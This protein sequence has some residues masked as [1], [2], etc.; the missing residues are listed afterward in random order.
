MAA[1]PSTGWISATAIVAAGAVG[2][3]WLALR[4]PAGHPPAPATTAAPEAAPPG[5]GAPA[6][7][8]D[9]VDADPTPAPPTFDVV[10]VEP[11]GQAVVAGTA[12]P[13]AAVTIYAD[14]TPLAETT[15]DSGGNFVAIFRAEPTAGPRALTLGAA[16]PDG[17]TA[18]STDV[19]MMLPAAPSSDV[20]ATETAAVPAPTPSASPAT[21]ATGQQ[22]EPPGTAAETPAPTV[23]ATAILR[24]GGV[25]VTPTAA[26]ANPGAPPGR[27]RQVS[28][29][30]ISYATTGDVTLAGLGT[31]GATLRAYVD[32]RLVQEAQVAP[33]GRWSL[34]LD[35]VAAGLYRL[36][37]DQLGSGGR[38]A[39]RVET[40]L[41]RDFPKAP[42]P[43]PDGS[44][45]T[46]PATTP[47]STSV[48]V[49]P[50]ANLWTIA[51]ERYGSGALYTQ[52]F[53]ANQPLIRDP[54]LI[55]PGQIFTLP[56]GGVAAA[57]TTPAPPPR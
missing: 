48:T 35:S 41:Q 42:P 52:I 13:G 54:A 21:A 40:P 5:S 9:V 24:D 43:R 16:G 1:L 29:A 33:D 11:D 15:A 19:V 45:A 49:Q 39:S 2:L 20:I 7:T 25:E 22:P 6:T 36:R 56:D 18:T 31:A 57:V 50:G 27:P 28:L 46:T 8:P 44:P 53:T 10:R 30:A 32:D 26:A 14:Q 4:D 17:A 34:S 47:D 3:G 37:I 12:A 23:A 38:V 55:Y 51:R